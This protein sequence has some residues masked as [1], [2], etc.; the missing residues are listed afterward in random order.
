MVHTGGPIKKFFNASWCCFRFPVW[1]HCSLGFFSCVEFHFWLLSAVEKLMY[2]QD[3]GFGEMFVTISS[4][5]ALVRP[6]PAWAFTCIFKLC[7]LKNGFMHMHT[8]RKPF[9]SKQWPCGPS[10]SSDIRKL[11]HNICICQH[12][13]Q[14]LG[15]YPVW[16]FMCIF[17]LF[18]LENVFAHS[19][20][21]EGLSSVCS[22]HVCLQTLPIL[23]NFCTTSVFVSN[24]SRN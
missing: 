22:D 17:K 14:K 19:S 15:L 21:A 13:L 5:S 4:I 10:N 6:L 9:S 23:E 16:A 18:P 11:L 24:F 8:C 3:C 7:T 12:F 20:H 1:T 2:L